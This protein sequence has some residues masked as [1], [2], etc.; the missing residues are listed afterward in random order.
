MT[1]QLTEA[2]RRELLA[3]LERA[4]TEEEIAAIEAALGVTTNDTGD[5]GASIVK[6][7]PVEVLKAMKT[8]RWISLTEL[9]Q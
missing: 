5:R 3:Q 7:V 4:E 9:S 2:R 8:A 6:L 1:E